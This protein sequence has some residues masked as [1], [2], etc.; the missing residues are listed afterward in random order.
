MLKKKFFAFAI[1]AG[2]AGV[3]IGSI[4]I[5]INLMHFL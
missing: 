5:A 4:I 2:I 1:M 3:I